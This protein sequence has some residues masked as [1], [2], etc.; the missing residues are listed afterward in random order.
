MKQ[1]KPRVRAY[2]NR[3]RKSDSY[4]RTYL[5]LAQDFEVDTVRKKVLEFTD[6]RAQ[7]ATRLDL[8]AFMRALRRENAVAAAERKEGT[9]E[10]FST[11]TRTR[12]FA[13]AEAPWTL[14]IK[15]PDDVYSFKV[16]R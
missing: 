3:S 15:H 5:S 2:Y 1:R 12:I 14:T 13:S 8:Y 6:Q 7:L 4:P 16:V 11:F 9:V 10:S